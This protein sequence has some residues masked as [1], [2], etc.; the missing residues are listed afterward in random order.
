M[1]IFSCIFVN[2]VCCDQ[3][4][5]IILLGRMFKESFEDMR[6]EPKNLSRCLEDDRRR[7]SESAGRKRSRK[8]GRSEGAGSIIIS[9]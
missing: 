2:A 5:A 4:L 6:L 8:A 1:T 3:Y 7:I 9:P